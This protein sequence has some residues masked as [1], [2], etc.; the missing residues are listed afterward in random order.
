MNRLQKKCVLATAGVHLLL[1]VILVVGPAFF[2]PRSKTD[3][4]Q[5]LDV[6]P[7]NLI[8]AAFNSGMRNAQPPPP[9][10]VITPPTPPTQPA[11][12][13]PKPVEPTPTFAERVEKI[14]K[15]EPPKPAPE[16]VQ[17]HKI[18]VD[19]HLVTRKAPKNVPDN[20]H[21]AQALRKAIQNLRKNF[22][23]STTVDMP[24]NSSVAYA[25]YASAV[26]SIYD[27]AWAQVPLDSVASED[28]NVKARVV[29]ASDGTVV[30]ARIIDSSGDAALDTSVRKTL[31]RVTFIAPFP[32]GTTDKQRAYTINFNPQLRKM[33]E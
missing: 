3:D 2:Q 25:N 6:I 26:K 20:P 9:A 4:L 15:S 32:E 14:F 24:G 33:L 1:L 31:E 11:L 16:K 13:P 18:Q 27:Q 7:A 10:P 12:P 8:D 17:P 22:S 23:P 21:Q 29:I 5:V 30:S 28:E 19:T